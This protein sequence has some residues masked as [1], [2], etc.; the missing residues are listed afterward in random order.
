MLSGL[1]HHSIQNAGGANQNAI[2]GSS[3]FHTLQPFGPVGSV[4]FH[5]D[6]EEEQKA[7]KREPGD[8]NQKS[9]G[10]AWA[11]HHITTTIGRRIALHIPSKG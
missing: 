10:D 1:Q 7:A 3:S 5:T 4:R 6:A 11:N 8:N 9:D 2:K